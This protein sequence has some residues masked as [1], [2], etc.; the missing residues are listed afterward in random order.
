M[1]QLRRRPAKDPQREVGRSDRGAV[2]IEA[3]FALPLLFALI[4]GIIDFG[5]AFNDWI[6]VRQGGRDGLR[7]AI[8]NTN[9]TASACTL[10][11]A[12]QPTGTSIACFTKDRVGL[13]ASNTRVSIYFDT[14]KGY[15]AG[16]PVKVCVQ[17]RTSSL[18]GAYSTVLNGKVL[19][20][21][22]ESL[23]EEDEPAMTTTVI[24]TGFI[25][26]SPSCTT[27]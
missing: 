27:L 12:T 2:L 9:P 11:G 17:Y 21:E 4:F 5:F 25:A 24:E 26:W 23:I 10:V 6:S 3:A 13:T 16:E 8:V 15:V 22:V 14:T 18:T 1:K 19:D 7:Q 20:T